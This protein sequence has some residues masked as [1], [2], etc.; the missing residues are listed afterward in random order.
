MLAPSCHLVAGRLDTPKSEIN[1]SIPTVPNGYN[2]LDL[3]ETDH[4]LLF[5]HKKRTHTTSHTHSCLFFGESIHRTAWQ[6]GKLTPRNLQASP[7]LQHLLRRFQLLESAPPDGSL[8]ELTESQ[9]KNPESPTV[10]TTKNGGYHA[11]RKVHVCQ[12]LSEIKNLSDFFV[13][14]ML[15]TLT[16]SVSAKSITSS[17][18]KSLLISWKGQVLYL[19][20]IFRKLLAAHAAHAPA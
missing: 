3:K 20:L 12:I 18:T 16:H 5:R 9:V 4:N 17:Q 2:L 14:S 19:P 1:F 13:S 7:P 11:L 8:R 6:P 10:F 15:V